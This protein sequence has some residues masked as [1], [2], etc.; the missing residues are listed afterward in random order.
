MGPPEIEGR[1]LPRIAGISSFGAGGSNG[2]LIV[3]EYEAPAAAPV[4]AAEVVLLLSAR[5]PEQLRQKARELLHF[6]RSRL[7]TLDLVSLAYTLQVGREAMGERLG[8]VATSAEQVVQKLEAYIAGEGEVEDLHQGQGKRNQDALAMFSSDAD[9]QQMVEKWMGSRKLSQLLDLWVKGLDVDWSKLYGELKPQRISLPTYPFARER[10]WIETIAGTQTTGAAAVLHPML[11]V[12]TS[13][14]SEQRYSS[15]FTG[16]EFFLQDHQLK[17]GGY[18]TTHKVFPGVAYLEM[19]RA[20]IEQAWPP[21]TGPRILELQNTVW[22]QPLVAGGRAQVGIALSPHG[23]DQIDFE[24]YS[25]E[26]DARNIHCQGRAA[27]RAAM[28]QVHLNVDEMK[29]QISNDKLDPESLY[30]ACARMGILY[31]PRFQSITGLDR[32]NSQVLA[33]LR[34]PKALEAEADRYVL[35]PS[36]MDGALHAY[37][38]LLDNGLDEPRLPFALDT[39]R[40]L[41]PCVPE[42]LV[43]LRFS[44][45]CHP[46]DGVTKLDIDVCDPSGG[47]CVQI[48][49]LALRPVSKEI[50]SLSPQPAPGNL[51][52]IPVWR[53]AAHRGTKPG[54]SEWSE[55]CVLLCELP[56]IATRALE[57]IVPNTQCL[58]LQAGMDETVAQRYS[59]YAVVCF[60]RIQKMLRENPR[61]R[62]HMLIAIPNRRDQ[63]VYAGLS[64]LLRTA[65][66]ENPS[67][68]GQVILVSPAT[69]TEEVGRIIEQENDGS[70]ALVQ[71]E[72]GE[73]RVLGWQELDLDQQKPPV[74]FKRGGVYLVTGG[75]GGIGLLFAREILAQTREATVILT[76]RSSLTDEKLARMGEVSAQSG[77]VCY[78]RVD[79]GDLK[80]VSRMIAEIQAEYGRLDGILHCAGMTRDNFI[81]KKTVSELSEVLMPKVIGVFNLDQATQ[82]IALDL[83]VLFSSIAGAT[84]NVGQADYA[85]ANAFMDFFSAQRNAEVALNRRRGRTLSIN[86]PLWQD[87]GMEMDAAT[88]DLLRQTT[89]IQPMLTATAM[90]CFYRGL[91]SSHDRILA[92]E[93]E[94]TKIRRLL[95][96]KAPAQPQP[97]PAAA[98][99]TAGMKAESL[100]EETQD[101]LRAQFSG[102][103]KMP[104]HRIDPQVALEDYGIDSILA[105][106]LTN[107]LEETFGPR[108]K[109]LF[110]EYQNIAGLA[111]YF[112]KAFP[113][114]VRDNVGSSRQEPPPG[115]ANRVP[116]DD[117]QTISS[118]RKMN[119]FANTPTN[120]RND[121]AIVGLEED[122]RRLETYR[123]SG[124]TCKT[125]ATAL[126]RSPRAL[127]YNYTTIPTKQNGQKL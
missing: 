4:R 6:L 109:T 66:L 77:Q 42:M 78:R 105:M 28:E 11:H 43:W 94:L 119:R 7:D 115:Q 29:A 127:G 84:G 32:G 18:P 100:I 111:R 44:P 45:T 16:D 65:A 10:Y 76:G 35:H 14:L 98:V 75:L 125:D 58:R 91:A 124:K 86:W 31:G 5:V 73:R 88:R 50:S 121:I 15:T 33:Y 108:S 118:I 53:A 110:F 25:S 37:V 71:Y 112:A 87:G 83:F 38:G 95:I 103:L 70:D 104:S 57:A 26:S 90:E 116:V 62:L 12:N 27:W 63:V 82:H 93:G 47:V 2:H 81:V 64:G 3:E 92:A 74:A 113:V 96:N 41:S 17:S 20:A 97:R 80:D 48:H 120:D 106:R 122:I 60:E 114:I 34:L 85:T 101:Y 67:F 102:L 49:G 22:L 52:A 1:R 51:L 40:I 61:A 117:T 126:P 99:Q 30:A 13:D 21:H 123:S 54:A 69:T 79:L 68:T 36:L 19:A 9:L 23:D 39:L 55:R 89:G 56:Q 8:F 107:R 72:Q 46:G 59:E 24:I